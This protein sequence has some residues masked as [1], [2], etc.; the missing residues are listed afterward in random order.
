MQTVTAAGDPRGW[1]WLIRT[2]LLLASISGLYFGLFFAWLTAGPGA[3]YEKLYARRAEIWLA[4]AAISGV[5]FV[6]SFFVG[7]RRTVGSDRA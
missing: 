2:G 7:R 3:P 6:A 4:I 5:A 1:R